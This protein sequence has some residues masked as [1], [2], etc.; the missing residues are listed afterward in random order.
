M[1]SSAQAA[2]ALQKEA[3]QSLE[4]KNLASTRSASQE[5]RRLQVGQVIGWG[6]GM[7]A[8]GQGGEGA[9]EGSG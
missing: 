5:R 6:T 8:T 1:L 3:L 2:R 7:G 9:V 4:A